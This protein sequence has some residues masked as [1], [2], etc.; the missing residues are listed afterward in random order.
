MLALRVKI[1]R[2]NTENKNENNTDNKNN[3]HIMNQKDL[4]VYFQQK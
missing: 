2:I 4:N 1:N 3:P